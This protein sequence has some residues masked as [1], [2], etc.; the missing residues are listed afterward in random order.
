M[1][2]GAEEE[3]RVRVRVRVRRR[4]VECGQRQ[5]TAPS[6]TEGEQL[7]SGFSEHQGDGTINIECGL[8]SET[9]TIR[10]HRM[11]VTKHKT[12]KTKNKG[13]GNSSRK[14]RKRKAIG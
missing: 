2:I 13:E 3:V 8:G 14:K 9:K 11:N 10:R 5:M 4:C 6:R 7:E 12:R 1:A